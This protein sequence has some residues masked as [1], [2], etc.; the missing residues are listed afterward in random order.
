MLLCATGHNMSVLGS[1]VDVDMDESGEPPHHI[2]S[3]VVF[4]QN[5]IMHGAV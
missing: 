4:S 2:N 5:N 3:Y 1:Q